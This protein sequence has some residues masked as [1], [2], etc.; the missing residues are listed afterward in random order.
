MNKNKKIFLLSLTGVVLLIGGYYGIIYLKIKA[1]YNSILTE[2]QAISIIEQET[3]SIEPL[4]EDD[5]LEDNDEPSGVMLGIEDEIEDIPT[6][7]N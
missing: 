1:A 4:T 6:I 3:K 5:I 2:Q 7:E